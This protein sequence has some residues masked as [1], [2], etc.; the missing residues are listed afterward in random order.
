MSRLLLPFLFVTLAGCAA[1]EP[2]DPASAIHFDAIVVDGHSDTT[3]RFVDPGWDFA[4]RHDDADGDMDL[5]R[6]RE[7]GLDVQFWSVY[8]GKLDA[9]GDGLRIAL[10][11]IDAV[12]EMAE[13]YPDDV[14]V[15]HSVAELR[16]AVANG[17]LVS[18][19][20]IEGG[21]IIEESLPALRLFHRL[22]G[23]G[24][25]YEPDLAEVELLALVDL[26]QDVE[27]VFA[28][29]HFGFVDPD[30]DVSVVVIIRLD[31][32]DVGRDA[33]PSTGIGDGLQKLSGN[34]LGAPNRVETAIQEVFHDERLD[35]EAAATRNRAVIAPL[36]REERLQ[37]GVVRQR[38]D[39]L[40]C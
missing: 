29:L 38:F 2:R 23:V 13:R 7:G 40:L 10:E 30:I 6:I 27:T 18:L 9:P 39:D 12:H 35:G 8:T 21:H 5:P 1:I 32:L 15:A 22:V 19:M 33:R 31:A 36:R 20:G 25:A 14:V 3:P 4:E 34:L 16:A 11:R 37:F 17:K 24:V 26:D 28:P